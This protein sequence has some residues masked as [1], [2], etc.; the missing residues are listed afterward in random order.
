VSTG[1]HK[2]YSATRGGSRGWGD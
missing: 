1:H 2:N